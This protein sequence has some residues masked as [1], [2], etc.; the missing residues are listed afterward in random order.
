MFQIAI[1]D[2]DRLFCEYFGSCV[3]MAAKKLKVE[4]IIS[5][6]H[7]ESE[8]I[9][10]LKEKG[11]IDVLFLDIE[12]VTCAGIKIGKY[13]RETL[14]DYETKLVYISDEPGDV[15]PI[16]ETEPMD[17]LVK[18]IKRAKVENVLSRFLKQQ[19]EREKVFTYKEKYGDAMLPYGS[20]WYFQSMGHKILIHMLEGQKEF[21][22]KLTDV[23]AIVP[24]YF[25]R[26]HKSYLVNENFISRFQ[27]DKVILRNE[28]KLTI[29]K[30]YRSA[31]RARIVERKGLYN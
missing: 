1:Y 14:L 25:V 12:P 27:Y 21:Y 24:D 15:M 3:S 7:T 22:G 5:V 2:T 23:E 30:S 4:C 26:I 19:M 9:E 17:F 28:Q 8:L 29:S 10:Y 16:F 20:I 11:H 6:W 13:I 31:I 18:P